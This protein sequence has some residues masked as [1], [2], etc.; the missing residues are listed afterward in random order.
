MYTSGTLII[1]T[2]AREGYIEVEIV[3][4][5]IKEQDE[6]FKVVLSNPVNATI[7]NGEGLGT[8]RN[9]DTYIDIPEDGYITPESYTGYELVW[10]DEFNGTA[11]NMEDWTYEVNGDGGGN[12]EL[13]YYTDRPQNSFLSNGNLVIEAKEE[14]YQGK[15]YTSARI[16]T[17]NKQLFQFGRVD[18]RAILPKGQGIWPALWMLG[19]NISSVGWPACGEIDIME[20]IGHQPSTVYGTIHSGAQGQGYSNHVGQSYTLNGGDF[21]DEYH[22]FSLI[23]EP[24]SIKWL[25]DDNQFFSITN[26]DVPGAYPFNDKFFFIFNVAVGGNWPGSPDGTTVFPQQ[27]IVDYVRVFQEL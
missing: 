21:S 5:I 15:Q 27:M 1:P 8:I 13:Q 19:T 24:N 20:L 9:D 6:E 23:W 25:V 11:L 16:V 4:D 26:A 7:V 3:G 10:G 14:S 2:G 18:I 17:Q 22:V 12:N